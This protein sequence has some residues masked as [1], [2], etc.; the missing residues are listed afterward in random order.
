[1]SD[2]FGEVI[3]QTNGRGN[4]AANVKWLIGEDILGLG[5]IRSMK[6]PTIYGDPDK[7]T[8]PLYYRDPFDNGGV[9][10]NSG[11]NNKAAYLM[12]EGGTFNGQTITG[13][14]LTKVSKIYYEV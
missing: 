7:M 3:D 13:L 11:L 14:G 8:S 10:F 9:H 1:L 5:A 6:D 2:V 4:D 12:V